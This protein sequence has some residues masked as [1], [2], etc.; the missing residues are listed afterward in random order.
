[1]HTGEVK[2]AYKHLGLEDIARISIILFPSSINSSDAAQQ[3]TRSV[4]SSASDMLMMC[5][6][7]GHE[8]FRSDD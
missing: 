5:T 3:L 2:W 7:D 6:D 1:M 8:G 4:K